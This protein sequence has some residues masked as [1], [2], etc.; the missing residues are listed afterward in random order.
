MGRN[1]SKAEYEQLRQ[2]G[3]VPGRSKIAVSRAKLRLQLRAQ[4]RF[5]RPWT[6][7]EI[8]QLCVLYT[9]GHTAKT[10]SENGLLPFSKY[11]V[12]KQLCRLGLAAKN[13]ICR[14]T[15]DQRAIFRRFLQEHWEGKTPEELAKL[16][17][18]QRATV[19]V[20]KKRVARYLADL[21]IKIPHGEVLRI[22]MQRVREAKIRAA[23]ARTG[24]SPTETLER[25]RRGRARI[26]R[27]RLE[28]GR[29]VF[30]GLPLP[31]QE[32]TAGACDTAV[33]P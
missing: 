7:Q 31:P 19:P 6:E 30:N 23:A 13:E 11:A 24:A 2:T 5:R 33:Q 32:L 15:P 4:E 27:R 17:N 16:W 9:Q 1:W 28:K 3:V 8:Q 29:D 26:M 21:R 12:Q 25:I 18:A 22:K 14:F 10:I 20:D